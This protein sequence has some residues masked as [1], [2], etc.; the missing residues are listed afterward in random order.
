VNTAAGET[1]VEAPPGPPAA[2]P[3][4]GVARKVQETALQLRVRDVVTVAADVRSVTLEA[5]DGAPLPSFTAGSHLVLDCGGR[6]NAYS[7]TGPTIEPHTYSISVLHQRFGKGGSSWMH[8]HLTAGQ[9]VT[10]GAPR[11]AFPPILT[12]KHHLY[13]AGGI[14]VTAMVSHVRNAVRWQRSFSVLYSYRSGTAAH[15][16]ELR[17][18]CGDR[19]QEMQGRNMTRRRLQAAL[20]EKP[21][22]THLYVC[23]PP[24]LLDTVL[25]L[26]HSAGWPDERLHLE[27]FAADELPPGRPFTAKVASTSQLIN[28]P[29]GTS[30]LEALEDADVPVPN[31]CRQGVCG[32]CRIGVRAG[33]L[34][35]RDLYLSPAERSAGN[36]LMAC[37]SRGLDDLVEL[38]L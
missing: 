38:D 29:S 1:A 6:R 37:V 19:L 9:V 35:H 4:P 36:S 26:A 3:A 17:Q 12:A 15:L 27:R 2:T 11:S 5:L 8:E 32:E 31:R 23:G 20:A 34:E 30:L 24:G 22:G 16:P 7:L 14:G 21:L 13:I 18:W 25:E 10:A 28:V 33:R